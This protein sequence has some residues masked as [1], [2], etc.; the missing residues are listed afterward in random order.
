M[1]KEFQINFRKKLRKLGRNFMVVGKKKLTTN[2]KCR[3][4]GRKLMEICENW[5]KI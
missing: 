2:D 5:N 3:K 1:L 4:F